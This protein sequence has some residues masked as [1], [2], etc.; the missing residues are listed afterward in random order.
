MKEKS[1]LAWIVAGVI[2]VA[3]IFLFVNRQNVA[4]EKQKYETES[5]ELQKQFNGLMTDYEK[6]KSENQDYALMLQEKDSIIY[7]NAE[8]IK[9]LMA[10]ARTA[11]NYYAL[12]KR[13]DQLENDF[14]LYKNE[15]DS[16]KAENDRLMEENEQIKEDLLGERTLKNQL[17]EENEELFGKVELAKVLRVRDL[18]IVPMRLTSC[19]NKLKETKYA[20]KIKQIHFSMSIDENRVAQPGVKTLYVRVLAPNN[21]VVVN[22]GFEETFEA[23][24]TT[25]KYT[26]KQD[27]EFSGNSRNAKVI[28]NRTDAEEVEMVKGFYRISIYCDGSEIGRAR[29]ELK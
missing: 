2:L 18:E 27:I 5:I 3:A 15:I 8:Q 14:I 4:K 6:V 28:W 10:K 12:K 19:G 23:D 29:F 22:K 9:V 1:T 11:D 13:Y 7:A 17:M 20:S 26:A 24:E 21:A 16:L 25:L